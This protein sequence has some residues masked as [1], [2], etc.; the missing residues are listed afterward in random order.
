MLGNIEGELRSC[1]WQKSMGQG[2][3]RVELIEGADFHD[4]LMHVNVQ[5][6]AI[7][8]SLSISRTCSPCY[9]EVR[10]QLLSR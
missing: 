9:S 7:G 3:S 8:R 4:G 6:L 1:W 2:A 10:S 5:K